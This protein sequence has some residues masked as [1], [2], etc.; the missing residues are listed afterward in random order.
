MTMTTSPLPLD[1]A[2]LSVMPHEE[3]LRHLQAARVGRVAFMADGY[4][5]VL[6]V[7]HKMDGSSVVFRTA[8]GSKLSAAAEELPVAF[9]VDRIDAEQKSG[10]SVLI[11]GAARIIDD[12][13]DVARLDG[14]GVWPWADAVERHQWVGIRTHQ[15]T[16]RKIQ[17]AQRSGSDAG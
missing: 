2:G 9:E 10:W 7:N 16:G 5:L 1:H 15:M 3:C 14:L 12:P 8:F 4:P 6:P 11:H 13:V 17:R